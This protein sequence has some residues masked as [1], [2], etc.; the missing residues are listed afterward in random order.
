MTPA[1][2]VY[3]F[4]EGEQVRV[5]SEPASMKN[6]LGGKG[7][8]TGGDDGGR[9]SGAVGLHDHD[10]GLPA[11]LRRRRRL[12]RRLAGSDRRAMRELERAHRQRLRLG[13]EP[14]ARL[15]AQRRA[16]LDA[17]HDGHDPQPRASTT[18]PSK[19]SRGSPTTSALR[20]M[21]TGASS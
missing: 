20:G 15:R 8:G 19:A 13:R 1:K 9:P 5:A 7:A 2:Y 18:K 16:R 12:P 17:R 4:D 14:A 6:M 10:A 11:V 3:F 21:R